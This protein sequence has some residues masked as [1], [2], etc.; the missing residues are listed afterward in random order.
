M[1]M[2]VLALLTTCF[3]ACTLFFPLDDLDSVPKGGDARL[4]DASITDAPR[5]DDGA[6]IDSGADARDAAVPDGATIWAGNGHAY[7][8]V[9]GGPMSYEVAKGEAMLAGG[10]LVTTTSLEEHAFVRGLLVDA[11]AQRTWLGAYQPNPGGANEPDKGW[12]WVTNEPWSFTRWQLGEPNDSSGAENYAIYY[13]SD[14]WTDIE[15][16]GGAAVTAYVVEFE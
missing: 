2:A 14:F 12:A 9:M 4:D 15:E 5:D 13:G 1:R 8:V 11:G 6:I 16:S 10:H 7:R 3:V